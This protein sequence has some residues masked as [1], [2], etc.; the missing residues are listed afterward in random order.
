MSDDYWPGEPD[1]WLTP[2]IAGLRASVRAAGGAPVLELGCGPGRDT[3][4]LVAAGLPVVALDLLPQQVQR[5]RRRVPR[6][7][8]FH[9]QDMRAPFPLGEPGAGTGRGPAGAVLASLSLHYFDWPQ[10]LQLVARIRRVLRPGGMLLCRLN[11][12]RDT[13]HGALD[14]VPLDPADPRFVRVGGWD[15]RFFDRPQVEA[16]FAQGWYWQHLQE[17]SVLR[18]RLPKVLWEAAVQRSAA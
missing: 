2:W 12:V 8:E 11:S 16:M 4:V 10:T 7:A 13:H 14:G 9:V 5:A 1:D 6:G 15:K 18:Y 3:E 17:R